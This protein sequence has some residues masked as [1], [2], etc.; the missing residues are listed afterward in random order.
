[1]A[2]DF[3]SETLD[4]REAIQSFSN[5]EKFVNPGFNIQQKIS[6]KNEDKI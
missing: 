2:A 6:F 5:I 1:M 3:S 4:Q